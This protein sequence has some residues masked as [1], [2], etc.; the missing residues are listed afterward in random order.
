V[1]K[2]EYQ[3]INLLWLFLGDGVA[4]AIDQMHT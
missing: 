4:G 1:Q 3:P 2:I